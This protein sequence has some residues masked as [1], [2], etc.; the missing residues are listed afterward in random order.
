MIGE[1]REIMFHNWKKYNTGISPREQARIHQGKYVHP[2]DIN[3]VKHGC[4]S[5]EWLAAHQEYCRENSRKIQHLTKRNK[6][7]KEHYEL[8]NKKVQV[9]D[10]SDDSE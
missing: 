9:R 6:Q 4:T 8:R 7:L 5:E 2:I 10:S 3:Y 1:E